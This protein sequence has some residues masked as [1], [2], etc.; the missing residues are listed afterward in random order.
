MYKVT[1]AQAAEAEAT[2]RCLLK[3]EKMTPFQAL[4]EIDR[5]IDLRLKE[6]DPTRTAR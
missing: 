5:I 6:T 1:K 2:Y 4:E 3:P